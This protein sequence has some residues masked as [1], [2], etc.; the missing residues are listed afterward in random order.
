MKKWIIV[1]GI[2][3]V[4]AG[5]G[6]WYYLNEKS[7]STT[8]QASTMQFSTA[9]VQKGKLEVR[10]SGSGNITSVTDT[11]ITETAVG[12]KTVDEVLVAAGTTVASGQELVS[13]TDGTYLTAPAAGMITAMN[14]VADD[15]VQEGKA[16]AHI[17]NYSDLQTVV[18]VDELDISKVKVGQGANISVSAFADQTFTGTVTAIANEGTVS[19]GVSTFDV[20]VHFDKS[21]NLK[22]G[23]TAEA[24][25]LTDSKDNALYVPV[26]AVHKNG[27]EKFVLLSQSSGLANASTQGQEQSG[28]PGQARRQGARVQTVVQTG[29]SNDNYVEITS[30]LTEGQQVVMPTVKTSS[31]ANGTGG[32]MMGGFGGGFGNQMGGQGNRSWRQQGM[33]TNRGG[34]N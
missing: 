4:G 13:F 23:M 12:T 7:Q 22:I 33:S 21:D 32:M 20:T 27:N 1:V 26:S 2:L 9:T 6:S 3:V 16:V 24:S 28:Q 15:K 25:I 29:I 34:A 11:D 10:V 19:N 18:G 5:G 14:V 30:G 31:N 17:K 8:A